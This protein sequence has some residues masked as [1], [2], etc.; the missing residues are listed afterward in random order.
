MRYE[1]GRVVLAPLFD[2]APMYLDPEGIARVCRWEGDAEQAGNPDWGAVINGLRE[3]LPDAT[4]HLRQFGQAVERLPETMRQAGVD[5][6]I[7]EN[8]TRSIQ[9][10]ARQLL[11]L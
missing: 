9:S 10:H 1:D 6:E 4:G 11:A 8:R 7:I 5:E 3:Y 2:F